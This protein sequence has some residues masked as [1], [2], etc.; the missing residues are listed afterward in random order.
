MSIG[1]LNEGPLHQALKAVY[2]TD[3]AEAEVPIGSYVADLRHPDDVLYEI[4]TAGFGQMRRKLEALLPEHRVVLV[5]PIAGIKHIV[6]LPVDAD[7]AE[8]RR[9]SPKRGRIAHVVGE[10]VSIPHLLDHPNFELEVVLTEE[11]EVRR[12]EP[13]RA[14]RRKGWVV[15]QR[16]LCQVLTRV[17]IRSAAD[18]LTLLQRPLPEQFTTRELA[19]ALDEPRW[20]AQKLAY[21]LRQAGAIEVCGKQGN[22]LSYRVPPG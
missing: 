19:D 18:L 13:D 17:R 10:L 3:G 15:V 5:H 14:W 8:S 21:C 1:T 9:R 6:K 7:G 20:V 16:R 2:D 4:Q 22:A 12:F 11:E